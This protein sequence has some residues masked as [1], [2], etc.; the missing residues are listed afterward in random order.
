MADALVSDDARGTWLTSWAWTWHVAAVATSQP[1]SHRSQKE[2]TRVL[3]RVRRSVCGLWCS[4]AAAMNGRWLRGFVH[5][6][7]LGIEGRL[8]WPVSCSARFRLSFLLSLSRDAI[9]CPRGGGTDI[10]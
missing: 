7:T 8:P 9:R 1:P 6:R 4:G 2:P 5:F 10:D 3:P